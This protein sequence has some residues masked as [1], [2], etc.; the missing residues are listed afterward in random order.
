MVEELS[1]TS[2][3]NQID[4]SIN[5]IEM[6][7]TEISIRFGGDQLPLPTF[8][9]QMQKVKMNLFEIALSFFLE[10]QLPDTLSKYS[11]RC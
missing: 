11:N 7:E 8:A 3:K 2:R 9:F 4:I 1:T 10:L 6:H 5:S